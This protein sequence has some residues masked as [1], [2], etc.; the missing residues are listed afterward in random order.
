MRQCASCKAPDGLVYD[1]MQRCICTENGIPIAETVHDVSRHALGCPR[2]RH[3]V[4]PYRKRLR[5]W[6]AVDDTSRDREGN[7]MLSNEFEY[8]RKN[9]FTPLQHSG[10]LWAEK[11][12]C[13]PC[14]QEWESRQLLKRDYE[15]RCAAKLSQEQPHAYESALFF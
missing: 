4:T 5:Q 11:L 2:L 14:V 12:M 3:F 9:G 6:R 8:L 15:A 13:K 7:P 10:F 1:V